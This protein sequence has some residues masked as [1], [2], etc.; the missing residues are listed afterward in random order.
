L[1]KS[2]AERILWSVVEQKRIIS[3]GGTGKRTTVVDPDTLTKLLSQELE[4]TV[5]AMVTSRSIQRKS[6]RILDQGDQNL[7]AAQQKLYTPRE[8]QETSS[9]YARRRAAAE[10]LRTT[11]DSPALMRGQGKK[12]ENKA[13]PAKFD[14]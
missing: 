14:D 13:R 4:Q 2:Q 6:T 7:E 10:R 3:S 11:P 12:Q 8:E 9:G 5:N 1:Y